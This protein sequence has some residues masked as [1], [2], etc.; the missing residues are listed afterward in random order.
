ME[1]NSNRK[2][3]KQGNVLQFPK[4]PSRPAAP[5]EAVSRRATDDVSSGPVLPV[6]PRP[7]LLTLSAIGLVAGLVNFSVFHLGATRSDELVTQNETGARPLARVALRSPASADSAKSDSTASSDSALAESLASAKT[8]N[9]ASIN[10]IGRGATLEEKLRW[11]LLEEKYTM[12][13]PDTRQIQSIS[14]QDP[15]AEPAYLLDRNKF[16]KEY[17][18]LLEE[19]FNSA[20]LNS[21]Q[22][23]ETKTIESYTLFDKDKRPKA[24]AQFELDRHKRL[25]SI[26]VK[27][28]SL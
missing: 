23:N 9:V 26:N 8:R 28:H 24:E 11:G 10:H 18:S 5:G 22:V 6:S 12:Y 14:L 20:Q 21:V 1:E 3:S 15:E 13:K 25:L 2:G 16:L 27:A 4:Q 7:S 19:S 17:G